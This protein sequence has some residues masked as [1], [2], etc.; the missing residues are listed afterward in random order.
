MH[1][2][3]ICLWGVYKPCPTPQHSELHVIIIFDSYMRLPH[4]LYSHISTAKG[5]P[6]ESGTEV[7]F[8]TGY[9]RFYNSKAL[10]QWWC[11]RQSEPKRAL[12][13]SLILSTLRKPLRKPLL[14]HTQEF[15]LG[16]CTQL[17]LASS[18]LQPYRKFV[19][20][21][22][23]PCEVTPST[24]LFAFKQTTANNS[25]IPQMEQHEPHEQ[26]QL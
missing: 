8:Q 19:W 4:M 26:V 21:G 15:N 7:C 25:D 2:Y 20:E 14:T 6:W 9:V 3:L 24:I 11:C 13:P 5:E 12:T 16:L 23:V 17:C 22:G 10:H 1:K 18:Q